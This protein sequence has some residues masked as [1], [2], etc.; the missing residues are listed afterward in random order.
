MIVYGSSYPGG[1]TRPQRRQLSTAT[2]ALALAV[3]LTACE[4]SSG[5]T[6][7]EQSLDRITA[8]EATIQ[9]IEFGNLARIRELSGDSHEGTWGSLDRFGMT[10]LFAHREEMLPVLGIDMSAAHA[11]TVAGQPPAAVTLIEGGQ[12]GDQITSAATESGWTDDDGVLTLE[13]DL[14][15]PLSVP[16]PH[17]QPLD[18]DVAIGGIE[19]DVSV[20]DTDDTSLADEPASGSLADCLG[21][22]AAAVVRVVDARPVAA[23]VRDESETPVSVMCAHTVQAGDTD[24]LA[25]SVTA[26]MQSGQT[27]RGRPYTD[28]FESPEVDVLDGGVVRMVATN[29]SE[30]FAATIL[31]MAMPEPHD[32]PGLD[33]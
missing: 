15:Q 26:A 5:G 18:T 33:R 30:S 12:D 25:R 27:A 31:Q 2:A 4:S 32:L 9:Y 1:R 8:T 10:H 28:F 6:A 13:T 3:T 22:V 20:V 7:L 21:D 16:A 17:V 29:T 11:A 23:G 24:E 14:T 19:A